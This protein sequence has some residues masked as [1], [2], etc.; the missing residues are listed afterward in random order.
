MESVLL[1]MSLIL[2]IAIRLVNRTLEL[3]ECAGNFAG[4]A[5]RKRKFNIQ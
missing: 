3:G 1:K 4:E 2:G 5:E